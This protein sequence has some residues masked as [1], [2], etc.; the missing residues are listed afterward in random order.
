M[1]NRSP[2]VRWASVQLNTEQELAS[3]KASIELLTEVKFKFEEYLKLNKNKELNKILLS[4]CSKEYLNYFLATI[5]EGE[6]RITIKTDNIVIEETGIKGLWLIHDK[7]QSWLEV[8]LIPS[9]LTIALNK[10]KNLLTLPTDVPEGVFASVAILNELMHT[11]AK[12]DLTQIKFDPPYMIELTRQPLS[13][14][15]KQFLL[16]YLSVG[17]IDVKIGGFADTRICDTQYN[18]L[19]RNTIF[20][21]AGKELLDSY[22]ICY[23]PPEVVCDPE[24]MRES[25]NLCTE[26]LESLVFDLDNQP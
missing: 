5:G 15:D 16:D 25:L 12:T 13:G 2:A 8:A 10:T 22:V 3:I 20:N 11:Q 26:L 1:T 19:W 6:V 14:T 24:E 21:N 9:P 17:D 23:L 18:G 4:D 7:H